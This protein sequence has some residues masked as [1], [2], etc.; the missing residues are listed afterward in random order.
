M[1]DEQHDFSR[2]DSYLR[3]RHRVAFLHAVWRPLLAGAAGA[4]LVVATVYVTMPKFSV[5][6]VIV[7]H[8][9][10]RDVPLN[11]P[12]PRDVPFDVPVPRVVTP[13]PVA[14][15]PPAPRDAPRTP[16]EQ[17]FHDRPEY[18]DATY[19][20]RIVKS[21]NGHDLSFADGKDFTPG[22]WDD[23][24][25]K[26]AYDPEAVIP[27]DEFIGDLGLCAPNK[28][29]A[30]MYDCTAMHNGVEVHVSG[31]DNGRPVKPQSSI[32]S[33]PT[34]DAT[35][36]INVNVDVGY[37]VIEAEVDTGCSWPMA[38]PR[39]LADELL[40]RGLATRAGSSKAELA[41]GSKHDVDV[42]LIKAITVEGR[43]LRDVEASVTA[44]PTALILLGLGA[45][46][47]LGP[48]TIENGRIVFSGSPT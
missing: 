26:V 19:H 38:M 36:M 11:N 4:A 31:D 9:V 18:K 43:V 45:L 27:S 28:T 20:G 15:N 10:T 40:K 39:S 17:K 14:A 29:H 5:R 44:S 1:S 46:N 32:G 30:E 22:H 6:E 42:I 2:V 12:V 8:V 25:G 48:Y 13:P 21:R 7:D 3:S 16:E 34:L 47:R 24:T 23:A 41:D 33:T 37:R 35:N